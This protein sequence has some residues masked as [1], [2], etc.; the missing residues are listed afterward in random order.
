MNLSEDYKRTTGNSPTCGWFIDVMNTK[1]A[2]EWNEEA[3][4]FVSLIHISDT[5]GYEYLV[6]RMG[7][8]Q[9]NR[10][11]RK[12]QDHDGPRA[13]NERRHFSRTP[14]T[15]ADM[16]RDV[17]VPRARA[18]EPRRALLCGHLGVRM[19]SCESVRAVLRHPSAWTGW[20]TARRW[21]V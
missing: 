3:G 9:C 13:V 21:C 15:I 2:V 7:A 10:E 16:C 17:A 14:Y 12:V 8:A 4:A 11:K 1:L 19:A 18:C 6:Q 5:Q 20:R